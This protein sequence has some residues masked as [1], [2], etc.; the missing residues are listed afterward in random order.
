MTL[1]P[2]RSIRVV[3]LAAA[4]AF[5]SFFPLSASAQQRTLD[6]VNFTGPLI[7][8]NPAGLPKGHWYIEPYLV[9]VDSSAYY[10]GSGQRRRSDEDSGAWV[11]VVPFI[12]GFSERVTGQVNLSASTAE[13]GRARSSGFRAGDTTAKLQYLLQA[14]SADGTRPAVSVALSQ[15]Y[16]TGSYDRIAGNP[17]NAQGD[18]VQRTSLSLAAQQVVWMPNDRPLRWRGQLTASPAPSRVALHGSSVYGTPDGF[19]G[20]IARGS[21]LGVSA[22]AEYSFNSRW[23]GVMEFSASRESQRQLTGYAPDADGVA[24]RIDER[25]PSSSSITLA[26][27]IEYHFSPSIGLIAGVEFSVAGRNSGHFVSPQVALGMFF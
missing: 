6:G 21:L 1:Q 15:R 13:S 9:R 7:T 24:R 8:P 4:V 18:G 19:R 20:S 22:A 12:Y 11:T 3:P 16:A 5:C 2:L 27:A 10:D 14:P 25:R 23:V 17:L 26:P